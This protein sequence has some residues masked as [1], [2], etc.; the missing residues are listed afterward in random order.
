MQDNVSTSD[1]LNFTPIEV[2]NVL[3]SLKTGKAIGQ[4]HINNR[5]LKELSRPLS[6]P[7]CELFNFSVSSGKVPDIWKQ[8]NI[9]PIFKKDDASDP[10]NYRPISLLSCIGKVLEKLAHKYVFNFFRDNAVITALQSGFMPGD[11][12]VNQLV[13]VYNTFCKALDE[14]KE[15]RAIFC[16]ISKAFERVWHEG[17]LFKLSLAGI[18][19]QLLDW[20]SDYLDNRFQRVVVPGAQSDWIGIKA[21]VPQGS[22][23]G[24]LL[25]LIYIND[26]VEDIGSIIR[27]FADDTS[28]YLV[29]DNPIDAANVLNSD[30]NKIHLWAKND[31]LP[32]ILLSLNVSFFPENITNLCI[33]H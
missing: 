1:T 5:I 3:K 15:V 19:G 26:I 7:L 29:V 17:L 20:F 12:T 8:A 9:T 18:K 21:G 2:E 11:S 16:D 4:D 22:I 10:S 33:H 27:L 24:P 30:L 6:S 23:L 25:F 32:L 28:L 31:L 14:G 13:D